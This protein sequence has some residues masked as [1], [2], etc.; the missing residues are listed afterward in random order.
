MRGMWLLFRE[1]CSIIPFNGNENKF[2]EFNIINSD[3]V[4]SGG[5]FLF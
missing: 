4:I 3:L 5:S 1:N 2:V